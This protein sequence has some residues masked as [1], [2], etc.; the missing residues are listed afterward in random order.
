MDVQQKYAL[1]IQQHKPFL[2]LDVHGHSNR[3]YRLWQY[4]PLLCLECQA[5]KD[6]EMKGGMGGGCQIFSK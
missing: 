3:E 6:R 4:H 1:Q 5:E 2:V